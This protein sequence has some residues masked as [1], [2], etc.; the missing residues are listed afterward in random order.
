MMKAAPCSFLYTLSTRLHGLYYVYAHIV[1]S[2][3]NAEP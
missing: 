1:H 2:I 3:R